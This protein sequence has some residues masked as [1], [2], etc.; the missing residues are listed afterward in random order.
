MAEY[1]KSDEIEDSTQET[2]RQLYDS[3]LF[4][5]QERRATV[6]RAEQHYYETLEAMGDNEILSLVEETGKHEVPM[7]G[8]RAV[9]AVDMIVSRPVLAYIIARRHFSDC[10]SF[11]DKAVIVINDYLHDIWSGRVRVSDE[12]LQHVLA[13]AERHR[14][15]ARRMAQAAVERSG[16]WPDG[17]C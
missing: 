7:D 8:A 12:S 5:V 3:A 9:V 1:M 13:A 16:D 15:S 11:Y 14:E 4:A 17:C 10:T 2:M 6:N